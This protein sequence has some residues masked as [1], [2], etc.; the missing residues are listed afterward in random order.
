MRMIR[1]MYG[2]TKL[3]RLWNVAF[4][5]KVGVLPLEEKMM[6][7]KLRWFGHVKRRSI[8]APVRRCEKINLMHCRRE[9]RL[10]GPYLTLF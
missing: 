6:E 9:R 7:T 4:R 3:D 5:E 8:N 1:W 10:S 2:Y